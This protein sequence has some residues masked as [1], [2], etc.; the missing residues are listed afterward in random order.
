MA[1]KPTPEPL[2]A[3]ETQ[4]LRLVEQGIPNKSI[5]RDLGIGL[6]TV[7][8]NVSRIYRKLGIQRR[9]QVIQLADLRLIRTVTQR[10]RTLTESR[11]VEIVDGG[12][13]ELQ[14]VVLMAREL[15]AVYSARRQR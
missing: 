1:I 15:L 10:E 6:S 14:E 2:T 12:R 13:A 8:L 4:I 9:W 5:A 11:L 3:R 7:K